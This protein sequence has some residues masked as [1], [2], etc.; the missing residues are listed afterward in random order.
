MSK[1]PSRIVT[2][3]L[4]LDALRRLLSIPIFANSKEPSDLNIVRIDLSSLLQEMFFSAVK[5]AFFSGVSMG[6]NSLEEKSITE[7]NQDLWEKVGRSPALFSIISSFSLYEFI[8][9]S[10]EASA[11]KLRIVFSISDYG[12][13]SVVM[14]NGKGLDRKWQHT[15]KLEHVDPDSKNLAGLLINYSN[16]VLKAQEAKET[17]GIASPKKLPGLRSIHEEVD[18]VGESLGGAGLGLKQIV[19]AVRVGNGD[20]S[21]TN[22]KLLPKIGFPKS[23]LLLNEASGQYN[24]AAIIISSPLYDESAVA[25]KVKEA[26]A[27]DPE[28]VKMAFRF[29]SDYQK[30][31]FV[32]LD[33]NKFTSKEDIYVYLKE[34]YSDLFVK[35]G[36]IFPIVID[37]TE[38]SYH[39]DLFDKLVLKPDGAKEITNIPQKP[40]KLEF[41]NSSDSDSDSEITLNKNLQNIKPT[42][43]FP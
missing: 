4:D 7:K 2:M 6:N 40:K 38:N 27:K 22:V 1:V 42:K 37:I 10:L 19:G 23:I 9:N 24:G 17:E 21:L 32:N 34:K 33:D 5:M 28:V 11:T 16:D 8:K 20:V 35:F 31:T 36:E 14:D 18:D 29:S 25:S 39:R 12:L 13:I 26:R 30:N 43:G 41:F 3:T 15:K